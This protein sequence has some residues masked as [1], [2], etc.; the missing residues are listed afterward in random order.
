MKATHGDKN[1]TRKTGEG[2]RESDLGRESGLRFLHGRRAVWKPH[3]LKQLKRVVKAAAITSKRAVT[4]SWK[5][6][7]KYG[8]IPSNR[9]RHWLAKSACSDM[10]TV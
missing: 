8:D 7:L 10:I 3:K 9:E 6:F 5:R 1:L 2:S 4:R